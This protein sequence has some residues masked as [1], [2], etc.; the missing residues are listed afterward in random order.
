MWLAQYYN[1]ILLQPCKCTLHPTFDAYDPKTLD[2]VEEIIRIKWIFYIHIVRT[3]QGNSFFHSTVVFSCIISSM[4]S[5][6]DESIIFKAYVKVCKLIVTTTLRI[7][8]HKHSLQVQINGSTC[9]FIYTFSIKITLQIIW[10]SV[11]FLKMIPEGSGW[12]ERWV[13]PRRL[14]FSDLSFALYDSTFWIYLN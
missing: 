6:L 9:I 5:L 4:L 12:S 2:G 3:S 11:Y 8:L 13:S 10:W 14:K 7:T 1:F